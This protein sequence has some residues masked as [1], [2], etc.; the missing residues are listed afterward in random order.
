V[1]VRLVG[2]AGD[3]EAEDDCL[4]FFAALDFWSL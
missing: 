2:K 1:P 3:E 4:A